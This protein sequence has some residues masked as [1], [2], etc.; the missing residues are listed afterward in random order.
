MYFFDLFT[1]TVTGE[2][3]C[4]TRE[5]RITWKERKHNSRTVSTISSF[6]MLFFHFFCATRHNLRLHVHVVLMYLSFESEKP[7][8]GYEIVDD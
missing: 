3:N 8:L 7:I 5:T 6:D 1:A 4:M 2:Q